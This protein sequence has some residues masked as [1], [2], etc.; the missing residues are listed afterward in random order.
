MKVEVATMRERKRIKFPTGWV[1]K[2]KEKE[3]K[4]KRVAILNIE[5]NCQMVAKITS[6][7]R[8]S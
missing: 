7:V 8:I 6:R 2:R 4:N 1:K 3:R 5:I